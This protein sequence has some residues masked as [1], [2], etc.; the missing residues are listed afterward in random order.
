MGYYALHGT[1][2]VP[3]EKAVGD[4]IEAVQTEL[5][6]SLQK[7]EFELDDCT[8]TFFFDGRA[9]TG[10]ADDIASD[11]QFLSAEGSFDVEDEDGNKIRFV[12]TKGRCEAFPGTDFTYYP[13]REKEFVQSL[14]S[15]VLDYIMSHQKR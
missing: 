4:V 15:E 9:Y 11:L 7:P 12:L 5:V 1:V 2:T 13:G 3:N 10:V 14:P 8:V 6:R